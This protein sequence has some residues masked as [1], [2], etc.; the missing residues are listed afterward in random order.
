MPGRTVGIYWHQGASP[1]PLSAKA[2]QV[3]FVHYATSDQRDTVLER[4]A[5]DLL[6]QKCRLPSQETKD[7][8]ATKPSATAAVWCRERNSG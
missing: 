8:A 3:T 6:T 2:L 1:G 5:H 7:V 4:H